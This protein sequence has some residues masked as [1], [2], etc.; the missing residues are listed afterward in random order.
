MLWSQIPG[1]GSKGTQEWRR[2]ALRYQVSEDTPHGRQAQEQVLRGLASGL[3]SR[4]H[5]GQ[6]V[7]RNSLGAEKGLSEVGRASAI[8]WVIL[9]FSLDFLVYLSRDSPWCLWVP[10]YLSPVG[11]ARQA[12]CKRYRISSLGP[13]S[14]RGMGAGAGG[15]GGSRK[16]DSPRGKG[17]SGLESHLL[18]PLWNPHFSCTM[19]I[20]GLV[21]KATRL[22]S[23][24]TIAIFSTAK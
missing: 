8:T 5:M 24:V 20:Q 10:A 14:C 21:I 7:G 12:H 17:D 9:G 4:H 13:V 18:S 3:R 23:F 15:W 1:W 19:H 6:P 2:P 22:L 16:K 11:R